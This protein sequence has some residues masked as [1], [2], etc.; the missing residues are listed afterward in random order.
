MKNNILQKLKN[1]GIAIIEDF[2]TNEECDI[3]INQI[4]NFSDKE[5]IIKHEDEGIGGDLRIFEFEKH[6]NEVL[7][8]S[9]NVFLK[10]IVSSYSNLELESKFTL[11]GKVAFDKNKKTNSGGDW[12]RDADVTQMKAMLY[13]SNV[14]DQN[15]PFCFIKKSKEFDFD[16]R[17][18]KYSFIQKIL[19]IIKGLPLTPPRYKNDLIM[20]QKSISKKILRV[21]GSSGTLVIFDGSYIHRGDVI[22]EGNRYSLTNY[23]YPILKNTYINSLKS[24]IKTIFKI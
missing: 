4:E 11:A 5:K 16:R 9:K 10:K 15:G 13:L 19:F 18:N 22:K 8:F 3:I 7:K 21:K 14:N 24:R 1:E 12:H 6:S 23:Y 17:E 20:K 2:L